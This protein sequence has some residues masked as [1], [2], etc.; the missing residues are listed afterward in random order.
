LASPAWTVTRKD[1]EVRIDVDSASLDQ[2][3][4]QSIAGA[5]ERHLDEG[6]VTKLRLVWSMMESRPL[7]LPERLTTLIRRLAKIVVARGLRLVI[8]PI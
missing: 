5:V 3:D 1:N 4:T 6:G 2:A 8:G 7:P